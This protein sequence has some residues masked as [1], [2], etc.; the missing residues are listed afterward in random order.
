M[1]LEAHFLLLQHCKETFKRKK[2]GG[3]YLNPS[4]KLS[5]NTLNI[6]AD[7]GFFTNEKRYF[8]ELTCAH[9]HARFPRSN[10][11]YF[12]SI[13]SQHES[14]SRNTFT[15]SLATFLLDRVIFLSMN[16]SLS[17]VQRITGGLERWTHLGLYRL[18][19][20]PQQLWGCLQAWAA[21]YWY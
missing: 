3:S 14:D 5:H 18:R 11:I 13:F 4:R 20:I 8:L 16:F 6:D 9:T 2:N 21:P 10:L 12:S 7:P 1:P 15:H 17:L 19:D